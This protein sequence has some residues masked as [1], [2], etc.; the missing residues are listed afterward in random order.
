MVFPPTLPGSAERNVPGDSAPCLGTAKAHLPLLL[1]LGLLSFCPGISQRVLSECWLNQIH[2]LILTQTQKWPHS[3]CNQGCPSHGARYSQ[4]LEP[5]LEILVYTQGHSCPG[6]SLVSSNDQHG[7]WAMS[8][9]AFRCSR[10]QLPKER[11]SQQ[12]LPISHFPLPSISLFWSPCHFSTKFFPTAA[13]TSS[14][15]W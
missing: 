12:C 15:S 7:C 4:L 3:R 5:R 10:L 6:N 9:A 8:G 11:E 1:H 13:A 2:T 14:Y